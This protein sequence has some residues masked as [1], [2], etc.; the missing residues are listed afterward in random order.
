MRKAIV[1]LALLVVGA[2]TAALAWPSSDQ[3]GLQPTGTEPFGW[4]STAP[5]QT[6]VTGLYENTTE[7]FSVVLPEGWVGEEREDNFPLLAI[8]GGEEDEEGTFQVRG[9]L[10]VIP[11]GDDSP[12]QAWMEGQLAGL[13]V[14]T[15][16]PRTYEGAESAHELFTSRPT[17]EGDV[18]VDLWTAIARGVADVPAASADRR[19]RLA[20]FRGGRLRLHG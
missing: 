18:V 13:P 12:A 5:Q 10:W 19:A 11:R 20:L 7:G 15:S 3:D 9:Q 17:E 2:A 1:V 4:P 16:E 14:V 6:E 8:M